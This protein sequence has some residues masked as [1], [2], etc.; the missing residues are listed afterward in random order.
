[1][2]SRIP[3]TVALSLLLAS[4]AVGMGRAQSPAPQGLVGT[5]FTYQGQ[6]KHNGLPVSGTCDFRFALWDAEADGAQVGGTV[7]RTDVL[8]SKGLFSILL[9]F[10]PSAFN[11]DE[12]YLD[13]EVRCPAG[14][15]DYT[16]LLPRQPITAVPYALALPGLRTQPNGTSPNVIGG[17]A[18]N[19]VA[20]GVVG[21]TIAGGGAADDF[22]T[23]VVNRVTA[24]FGSVGGGYDNQAGGDT[25]SDFATVSGGSSNTAS[26]YMSAIGGGSD[27][28]AASWHATIGGGEDNQATMLG[29]VSGGQNNQAGLR[30]T[31]GGGAHNN[32]S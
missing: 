9:D 22:G 3:L 17:C 31:I 16:P 27:N 12:R 11:G 28:L 21:A 1:M 25:W 2:K 20:D 23:P 30:S 18:G 7:D 19:T 26:G 32:A 13:I 5:G 14:G 15:G 29:T 8:V 4:L 6:L 10:G 24:N